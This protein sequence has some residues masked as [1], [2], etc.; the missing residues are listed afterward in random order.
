[1]SATDVFLLANPVFEFNDE[2]I[3]SQTSYEQV[4][5]STKSLILV[6]NVFVENLLF[7]C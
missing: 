5:F 4:N 2:G 3:A 1:M 7:Y 6:C